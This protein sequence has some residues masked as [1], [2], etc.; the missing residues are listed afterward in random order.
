MYS[1]ALDSGETT[2]RGYK[3]LMISDTAQFVD[4]H[5]LINSEIDGLALKPCRNSLYLSLRTKKQR[6]C[7]CVLGKR[8]LVCWLSCK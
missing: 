1:E 3:D 6:Y 5:L 7:V 4:I 8:S 2:E